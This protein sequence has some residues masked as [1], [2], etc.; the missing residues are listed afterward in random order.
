M[1]EYTL[2][3]TI[4][5]NNYMKNEVKKEFPEYKVIEVDCKPLVDYP[6]EH[7]VLREIVKE[8]IMNQPVGV[9]CHY[10]FINK[11]RID[12]LNQII[13]SNKKNTLI[14]EAFGSRLSYF[15]ENFN[16]LGQASDI[17]GT[18]GF[19]NA[20]RGNS[21]DIFRTFDFNIMFSTPEFKKIGLS[22]NKDN[23]NIF[24]I[25]ASGKNK[26]KTVTFDYKKNQIKAAVANCFIKNIIFDLEGN[27]KSIGIKNKLSKEL[28]LNKTQ[29]DV[30]SY[31]GLIA[32]VER[33]LDLYNL[34]TD[35]NLD[36]I[37]QDIFDSLTFFVGNI[38]KEKNN[39]NN[40]EIYRHINNM[41]SIFNSKELIFN[42]NYEKLFKTY[43]KYFE[44]RKRE[45]TNAEH[46]LSFIASL[47]SNNLTFNTFLDENILKSFEYLNN[48][49]DR[50]R[51]NFEKDKK[52][53]IK[54]SYNQ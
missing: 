32:C 46:T 8:H 4:S 30:N 37:N 16:Y 45:Q 2:Q 31:S 7:T 40:I 52:N 23:E 33:E 44:R 20:I 48:I 17:I 25:S 27:I 6:P 50:F 13:F 38:I 49:S 18:R 21:F 14:Y 36:I 1:A 9:D 12:Y 24:E 3:E 11:N 10:I 53:K 39:I 43:G 5:S 29:F 51:N 19:E 28:T 47:K 35:K 15:D 34:I 54:Q 22:I 41:K 26:V 42:S